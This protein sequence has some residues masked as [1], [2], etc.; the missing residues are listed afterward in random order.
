MG[1]IIIL[2]VI[3]IIISAILAN[4]NWGFEFGEFIVWCIMFTMLS[5]FI[6]GVIQIT[7]LDINQQEKIVN[8]TVKIVSLKDNSQ[9]NGS[10]SLLSKI[11]IDEKEY[12]SF[13]KV[14]TDGS[15]SMD[16]KITRN[17][18]IIPDATPENSYINITDKITWSSLKNCW[19]FIFEDT[20]EHGDYLH[21]EFH[22]PA[23]SIK[24]DYVLDAE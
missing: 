4:H 3:S 17:S 16:K 14:N 23:N 24:N 15:Y 12:F 21:G 19:W 5:A 1:L 20:T 2:I 9:I 22:V 6:F 13:Y 18:V 10:G 8:Y 11:N 7:G